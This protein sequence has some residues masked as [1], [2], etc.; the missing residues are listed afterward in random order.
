MTQTADG[1]E[2]SE[3]DL[4]MR[5]AGDFFG[6]RQHGLPDLKIADIAADRELLAE[7]Q[8]AA[9]N[10]L[11]DS[12]D[13]EKYPALKAEAEELFSRNDNAAEAL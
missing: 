4:K 9:K 6:S 3:Y 11:E 10:I 1:F 8:R 13:L 12:P 5:G 2:I 7:C